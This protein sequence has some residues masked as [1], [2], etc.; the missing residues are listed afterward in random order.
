MNTPAT[1]QPIDTRETRKALSMAK[2]LV[3]HHLGSAPTRIARQSGGLRNIV[4]TAQ[5]ASEGELIIRL[6]PNPEAIDSFLKEAEVIRRVRVLGVPTAE[7]LHV[8]CE[9]VEYPYMLQRRVGG[10]EATHHP[11]RFAILREMGRYAALI[12]SMDTVGF[13]RAIV[14][15]GQAGTPAHASW[16]DYLRNELKLDERLETLARLDVL[17]AKKI[18]RVRSILTNSELG[19][20]TPQLNHGDLRLKNVLADE[21]GK[22]TAIIDWEDAMSSLAPQWEWSIA[23]HDLSVDAKQE[24]LE[25]YGLP[26]TRVAEVASMISALNIVNYVPHIEHLAELGDADKLDWVRIRMSGALDLYSL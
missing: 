17:G 21:A 25:G 26:K 1:S 12:N 5:H 24:L 7:V 8:G 15:A 4:Y 10:R 16:F 19:S 20:H 23:L 6:S 14:W 22:I 13:G 3:A 18:D 11:E 2:E 9:Q